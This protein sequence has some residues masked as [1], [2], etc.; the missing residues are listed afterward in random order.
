M[1]LKRGLQ[2]LL[3]TALAG[4]VLAP[5]RPV[6]AK[7]AWTDLSIAQ[8][9][10]ANQVQRGETVTYVITVANEG[11]QVASGV[12]MRDRLPQGSTL[13]NAASGQGKCIGNAEVTCS[14]GNLARGA[15]TSIEIKI[16][17]DQA[18]VLTN[19][20]SVGGNEPDR[21]ISDNTSN[22]DLNVSELQTLEEQLEFVRTISR[23]YHNFETASDDGFERKDHCVDQRDVPGTGVRLPDL[24]VAPA[25]KGAM[26]YHHYNPN[27]ID[28][29]LDL[30]KPEAMIYA[31]TDDGGRK[32]VAVEYIYVDADQNLAT[33][34]EVP[35]LFL[36]TEDK[37]DG[38][39]RGH[40]NY[41][42]GR[43]MPIHYDL[44]VWVWEDNPDGM[45]APWNPN[46]TCPE[47]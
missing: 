45:F 20:V 33:V 32:L 7:P 35:D 23:E 40:G 6:S 16:R 11:P 2:A 1:K 13:L 36:G 27:R 34:E 10:S 21:D 31:P 17:A 46:V 4:A 5:M 26:G 8:Q 18:G 39:M 41:N 30:A 24:G 3:V 22:A 25:K 19:A 43:P 37:F 29:S 12:T 44:H 47:H 42:D 15:T 9:G 38:P 14:I 28:R